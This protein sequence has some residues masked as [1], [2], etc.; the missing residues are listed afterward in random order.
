MAAI[1][2]SARRQGELGAGGLG[3]RLDR[4]VVVGRPEPPEVITRS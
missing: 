1:A 4:A 2:T 3:D